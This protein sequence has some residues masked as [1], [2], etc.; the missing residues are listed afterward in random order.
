MGRP[1]VY[2]DGTSPDIAEFENI[3]DSDDVI[4]NWLR[5]RKTVELLGVWKLLRLSSIGCPFGLVFWF[6]ISVSRLTA[7]AGF[8]STPESTRE[9]LPPPGPR[10][11][12]CVRR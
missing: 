5:N 12:G 7:F 11:A 2:D 10:F 6:I 1:A 3:D 9:Q 4:G 8:A